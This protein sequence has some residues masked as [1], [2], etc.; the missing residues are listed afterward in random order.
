MA[1]YLGGLGWTAAEIRNWL[2]ASPQGYRPQDI[3]NAVRLAVTWRRRITGAINRDMNNIIPREWMTRNQSLT[4]AF[5]YAVIFSDT[6]PTTGEERHA[7]VVVTSDRNLTLAELREEALGMFAG[8]LGE[9]AKLEGFRP[10]QD[11]QF[12]VLTAERR[13]G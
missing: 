8:E 7:T 4:S 9:S 6:D 1:R 2:V 13:S 3:P 5:R 10:H 12:R 11:S